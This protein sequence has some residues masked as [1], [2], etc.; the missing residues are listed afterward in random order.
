MG[1]DDGGGACMELDSSHALREPA[2]GDEDFARQRIYYA[3]DRSVI[4]LPDRQCNMT[5]RLGFLGFQPQQG[6]YSFYARGPATSNILA[7][8]SVQASMLM[9]AGHHHP[10][11]RDVHLSDVR[12]GPR[13]LLPKALAS[14]LR[15]QN[16]PPLLL[17][18]HGFCNSFGGGLRRAAQLRSALRHR[19][20]V[21]LYSW[22]SC[23]KMS[24]C[25]YMEDEQVAAASKNMF[26][27]LLEDLAEAVSFRSSS[28]SWG[29]LCR[30]ECCLFL[31]NLSGW[32]VYARHAVQGTTQML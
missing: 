3:T 7:Y 21:L 28:S 30:L 19:G 10:M 6:Q 14:V 11:A 5:A 27:T 16:S 29:R 23:D 9:G 31:L 4:R 2:E 22:P 12:P 8:G 20:P 17:Y 26:W 1:G 32:S 24:P 25:G 18:I 13:S 15:D